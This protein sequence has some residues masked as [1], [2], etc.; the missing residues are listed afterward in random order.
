MHLSG[1]NYQNVIRREKLYG[2]GQMDRRFMILKKWIPGA[3]LPPPQG[4]ILV[5]YHNIQ[6]SSSLKLF[7]QSKP[8]VIWS[9]LRKGE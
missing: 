5:Y 2:N 3:G 4:N 8:D 1:E 9:I 6:R 7:G